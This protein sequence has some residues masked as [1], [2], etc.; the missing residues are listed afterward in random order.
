MKQLAKEACRVLADWIYDCP[1]PEFWALA[2]KIER[3]FGIQGTTEFYLNERRQ[4]HIE[5]LKAERERHN[6][7]NPDRLSYLFR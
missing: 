3:R 1:L 4:A 5:F 7:L 6:R 2:D